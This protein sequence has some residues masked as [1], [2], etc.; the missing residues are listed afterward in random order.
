MFVAAA[1]V[2]SPPLLVPELAGRGVG[3]TAGLR[4]AAGRV[5][6]A[7]AAESTTWTAIGVGARTEAFSSPARGTFRGYGADVEVSFGGGSDSE[8][9]PELP[10]AALVAGWLRGAYATSVDMEVRLFTE[11]MMPADCVAEG[12]RLRGALD[13]DE[14][15]R[16]LLVI[17]DGAN[18]LTPK[19]PGAFDPASEPVQARID[20]A[21]A[22]GRSALLEGLE[23]DTARRFGIGGRVAWQILAGVFADAEP[24]RTSTEYTGAPYGVGY[25][26]GMWWR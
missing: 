23:P 21:L 6:S 22:G 20:Q 25:H 3:E 10:L 8:V 1:L 9:D 4:A 7:L 2:P 17:G 26:V 19:A 15:P 24:T 5:V 11:A 14:R 13:R 16:G 12:E 18:T